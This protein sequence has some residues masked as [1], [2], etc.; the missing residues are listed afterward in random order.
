MLPGRAGAAMGYIGRSRTPRS[1]IVARSV[2]EGMLRF[3]SSLADAAGSDNG[4]MSILHA[5]RSRFEPALTAVAPNVQELL[6]IIRPARDAKFGDY[7]ANFAM[8]LGKT[9]GKPPREVAQQI[10]AQTKLDDLCAS[11][12]VAGPGFINLRLRDDW[13]ETRLKKAIG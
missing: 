6:A 9:L 1:V 4:L 13:L 2:G 3:D 8:S 10:V 5:L 7:Q 11:V 12:E